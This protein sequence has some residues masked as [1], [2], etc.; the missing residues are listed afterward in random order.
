[1]ILNLYNI[2]ILILVSIYIIIN[3][4]YK[5][6]LNIVIITSLILIIQHFNKNLINSIVIAYLISI[7]YGIFKN[8]HLLENFSQQEFDIKY[9]KNLIRKRILKNH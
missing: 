1:M 5:K 6:P 9:D 4:I 8:F 2:S 3:F 7:I